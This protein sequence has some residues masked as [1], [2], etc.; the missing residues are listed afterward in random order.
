MANDLCALTATELLEHYRRHT[1][2]PVEVAKAV[3]SRI[4]HS[5]VV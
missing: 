4:E 2:S 1:L 3:Q 5:M